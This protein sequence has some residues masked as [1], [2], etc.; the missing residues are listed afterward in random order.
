MALL[1][2]G[3]RAWAYG[4][5]GQSI[6]GEAKGMVGDALPAAWDRADARELMVG[7]RRCGD[8]LASAATQVLAPY[9]SRP[10]ASFTVE[11]RLSEVLPWDIMDAPARGLVLG[12][13]RKTVEN[14]FVKWG[15]RETCVAPNLD[16]P[17]RNL[18]LCTAHAAKGAEADD[19]YL[20]PNKAFTKRVADREP[21]ALRLAYVAMTRAR[22]RFFAPR[23]FLAVLPK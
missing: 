6:Y 12:Y 20:L 8:P 23:S 1:R 5:P 14:W 16:D 4:D 22:R 10:A 19:V 11:G 15:L 7:G 2:P 13:S 18:V 21:G 9:W 3:G 17:D